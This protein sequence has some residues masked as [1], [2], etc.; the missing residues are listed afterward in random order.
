MLKKKKIPLRDTCLRAYGTLT[1][2]ALLDLKELTE[3][4]VKIKLGMA[5]GFFEARD[6]QAFN[7]FLAD[8]RPASFRLENGL[9]GASEYERNVARAEIV[10][11]VLPELVSRV[12]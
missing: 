7:D 11:K 12:D 3:G 8:M 4:M 5:L 10:H 1:N 9:Q 6:I 2:C